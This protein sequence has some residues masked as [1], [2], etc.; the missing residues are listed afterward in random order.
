MARYAEWMYADEAH[1]VDSAIEI[2][3]SELSLLKN[4]Y[5]KYLHEE[6]L[7]SDVQCLS[8]W[9]DDYAN[10]S[11]EAAGYLHDYGMILLN[12]IHG[13]LKTAADEVLR[14]EGESP[15]AANFT[16]GKADRLNR[17][18]SAIDSMRSN[19]TDLDGQLPGSIVAGK[20]TNAGQYHA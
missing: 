9:L 16:G 11:P 4:R 10:G 8:D 7:Q 15:A 1:A 3:R 12:H 17:A 20:G 14:F 2:L 6:S 5:D 13:R 19:L 18:A